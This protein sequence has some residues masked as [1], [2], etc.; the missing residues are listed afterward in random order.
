VHVALVQA[1]VADPVANDEVLAGVREEVARFGALEPGDGYPRIEV[2]VLRAE[3]SSEGIVVSASRPVARGND[4]AVVGRAWFVRTAGGERES[5]SGDMRAEDVIA[6]DESRG[7]GPL[8]GADPLASG[9]HSA[10][11]LRAA[12]RRLGRRLALRVIGLPASSE[13]VTGGP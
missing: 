9:F 2:E 1:L 10:D 4:I 11:A 5:D 7:T 6:V 12:A 8:P 3:H 13:D